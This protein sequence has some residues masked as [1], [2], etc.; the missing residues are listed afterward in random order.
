MSLKPNRMNYTSTLIPFLTPQTHLIDTKTIIIAI[1]CAVVIALSL[2]G[3]ALVVTVILRDKRL[4]NA[5]NYILLSLAIADLTV[6]LLV[7]LPSM[8]YDIKQ[9][10]I[11]SRLF[12]KFY[13][14][15]DITCCTAS[16][17]HL[18]LVAVDRYIAIFKPLS[19]RNLVRNRYV[20]VMVA[21]VWILSLCLSYVDNFS[22]KFLHLF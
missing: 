15:F 11:F 18:L 4:Q 5:T 3:N 16:I 22:L 10:W 9:K 19:Y 21:L 8:I 6:S 20:F 17:L 13:N 12:C 14:S 1:A 7:M 2:F